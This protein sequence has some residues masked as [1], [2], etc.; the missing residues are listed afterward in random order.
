MIGGLEVAALFSTLAMAI[1]T[2]GERGA[3]LATLAFG[4]VMLMV[5]IWAAWI[6]EIAPDLW[7]GSG[8]KWLLRLR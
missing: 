8:M 7:S 1:V 6:N 5:I 2:W 4:C 3:H